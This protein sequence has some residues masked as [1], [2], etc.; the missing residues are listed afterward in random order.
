MCFENNSRP[1][2]LNSGVL[3]R[4]CVCVSYLLLCQEDEF[5][6]VEVD[7]KYKTVKTQDWERV[8]A[9]VA[10]WARDKDEVTDEEYQNFYKVRSVAPAVV[11]VVAVVAA[12]TIHLVGV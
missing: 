2:S 8:N 10:V 7:V 12:V 3:S 1:K 6:E 5:E 4:V 11:V 9:N